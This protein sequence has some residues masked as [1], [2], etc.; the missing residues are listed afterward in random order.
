MWRIGVVQVVPLRPWTLTGVRR[1]ESLKALS[2]VWKAGG[3]LSFLLESF[4]P[5][6][7]PDLADQDHKLF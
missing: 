7:A 1:R 2:G 4:S 6:A 3:A 5:P